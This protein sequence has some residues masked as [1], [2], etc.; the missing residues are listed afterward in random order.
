MIGDFS[1]NEMKP[2][3]SSGIIGVCEEWIAYI[4]RNPVE[5]VVSIP[6]DLLDIK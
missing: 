4:L 6:K 2:Y 5:V 1:P 3:R